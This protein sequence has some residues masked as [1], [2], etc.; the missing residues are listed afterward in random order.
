[1]RQSW[2]N[3]DLIRHE[4]VGII[5][6]SLGH[7]YTAAHEEGIKGI[8]RALGI[9]HLDTPGV[10]KFLARAIA[11]D[12]LRISLYERK[13]STKTIAA[14]TRLSFCDQAPLAQELKD[15]K[16]KRRALPATYVRDGKADK[17]LSASWDQYGFCIRAFGDEERQALHDIHAAMH[18]GDLLVNLGGGG[19]NPFS[20]AGL[21]L[22]I[23]SRVPAAL[24]E[25]VLEQEAEARRL[26]EAVDATNIHEKLKEAGCKFYALKPAWSTTFKTIIRD[27][28]DG[29][30][31]SHFKPETTHPVMFFLNPGDQGSNNHGWYTVEELEAWAQGQGPVKKRSAA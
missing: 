18:A 2:N 10:E 20:R 29:E 3:L 11:S 5:G 7:D 22:T 17:G 4:D 24:R 23:L 16:C 30:T 9:R 1:M 28:H 27:G 19:E 15:P 12:D 13:K 25:M 21:C 6:I 26:Q 31:D 8:E 14:E